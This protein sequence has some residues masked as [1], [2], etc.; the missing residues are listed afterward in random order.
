MLVVH[1]TTEANLRGILGSVQQ[2]IQ[3]LLVSPK[4]ILLVTCLDNPLYPGFNCKVR[5][6]DVLPVSIGLDPEPAALNSIPQSIVVQEIVSNVVTGSST[7]LQPNLWPEPD[8]CDYDTET[9]NR[10][11][12][13]WYFN[14]TSPCGGAPPTFF[15][16][17]LPNQTI[18]GVLR[19]HS[20]RLNSSIQ[21]TA[22]ARSEFPSAC[23]GSR[24]FTANFSVH[25]AD[26]PEAEGSFALSSRIC[27]PGDY[28]KG[29]WSLSRD[30]QDI[31]E[32]IYV[33]IT[34]NTSH[35]S[36]SPSVTTQYSG[37]HC[38]SNTTRGYFEL[39]NY[40]NNFN[41]QPL[42]TSWPSKEVM[43]VDFNDYLPWSATIESPSTK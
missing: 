31:S 3:S 30:R 26:Y 34:Q 41:Y 33:E 8:H 5:L 43:E 7:D 40:Q 2:P 6:G 38:T 15:V 10:N 39:G 22:I 23:I 24:P 17:A 20:M 11:S 32:T 18:T 27:V 21:C 36:L 25:G 4:D 29:A 19:Q 14:G 16:S 13:S 1:G 9:S 35:P 28:S 42:L 12:L 37:M